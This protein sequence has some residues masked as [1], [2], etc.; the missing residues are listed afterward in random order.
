VQIDFTITKKGGAPIRYIAGDDPREAATIRTVDLQKRFRYSARQV[1]QQSGL[2]DHQFY[3][4][5]L[6][7]NLDDVRHAS[8]FSNLA[9]KNTNGIRTTRY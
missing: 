7:L 8:S 1:A 6:A 4:A 9:V 2:S 3:A 5:H